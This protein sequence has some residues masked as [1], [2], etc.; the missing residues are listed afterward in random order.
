MMILCHN[1]HKKN[2][3][4]VA[5][6]SAALSIHPVLDL[7]L[8]AVSCLGAMA[9]SSGVCKGIVAKELPSP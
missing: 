7:G 8:K 5:V 3:D 1:T 6:V 4:K 9:Q 2:G